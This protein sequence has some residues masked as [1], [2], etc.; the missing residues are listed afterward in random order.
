M[1]ILGA[2]QVE[3]W[4]RYAKISGKHRMFCHVRDRK[5]VLGKGQADGQIAYFKPGATPPG[6]DASW[7]CIDPDVA[8]NEATELEMLEKAGMPAGTLRK[9]PDGEGFNVINT[10]TGEP[11]NSFTLTEAEADA[12]VEGS[13]LEERT[14]PSKDAEVEAEEV[15][16]NDGAEIPVCPSGHIFGS[17]DH[18]NHEECDECPEATACKEAATA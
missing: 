13:P 7:K 15:V 3:G 12:I 16:K 11:I 9:E 18:D 10:Q 6:S 1:E 17:E 14:E 5:V 4:V 2:L 8:V